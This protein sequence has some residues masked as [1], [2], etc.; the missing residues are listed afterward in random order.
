MAVYRAL[1]QA[2]HPDKPVHCGLVWTQACRTDWLASDDLDA[3]LAS[4][5]S[6]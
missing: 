4:L 5:T 2:V 3:A 6:I 1:M